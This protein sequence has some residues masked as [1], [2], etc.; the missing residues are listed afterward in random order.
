MHRQLALG[1][2]LHCSGQGTHLVDGTLLFAE[3]AVGRQGDGD[4][5]AVP[6]EGQRSTEQ[7]ARCPEVGV[8][9]AGV[10]AAVTDPAAILRVLHAQPC[11][12]GS[13]LTD[14]ESA[15][16]FTG[17]CDHNFVVYGLDV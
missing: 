8:Q 7:T 4:V 6:V 2:R 12:N 11:S 10:L 17:T 15:L 3:L 13:L 9:N 5:A 1:N 14:H 16:R